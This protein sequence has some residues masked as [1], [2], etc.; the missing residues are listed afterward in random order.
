M[1]RRRPAGW[2]SGVSPLPP[3]TRGGETPPDQPAGRR[4]SHKAAYNDDRR[5]KRIIIAVTWI[6]GTTV[7]VVAGAVFLFGCCVLPFHTMVH[8]AMPACHLAV[9]I[10]HGE[11]Q[12]QTQAPLPA[13]EK[14]EPAKRIA[15]TVPRSTQLDLASVVQR[16]VVARDATSYRSF[17]SLGAMRCDRDVGLHLLVGTLL[18]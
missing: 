15:T 9:E 11:P 6:L 14:Q 3:S 4:R 2:R 16:P 18:I 8:K 7:P 1:D 12:K 10:L 13:H 5:M 17:I